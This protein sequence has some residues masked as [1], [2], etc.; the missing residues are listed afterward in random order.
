MLR[1][2]PR[3]MYTVQMIFDLYDRDTAVREP[4]PLQ[5]K[6][7]LKKTRARACVRP[8]SPAMYIYRF[9]I[10]RFS[11]RYL[12]WTLSTVDRRTRNEL[13]LW[14]WCGAY[15][16]IAVFASRTSASIIFRVTLVCSRH[17]SFGV[18]RNFSI[19]LLQNR[20]KFILCQSFRKT[21][22]LRRYVIFIWLHS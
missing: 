15:P 9:D 1:Y 16:A 22:N 6:K 18:S 3:T 4:K 2:S 12:T 10:A 19:L 8:R 21:N 11:W 14:K 17:F 7:R 13:E 5:L 20:E